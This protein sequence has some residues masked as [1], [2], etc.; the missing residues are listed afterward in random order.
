MSRLIRDI[1]KLV[2][3]MNSDAKRDLAVLA[4][5]VLG[6]IGSFYFGGELGADVRPLTLSRLALGAGGS[7]VGGYLANKVAKKVIKDN[8]EDDNKNIVN[9]ANYANLR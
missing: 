7:L 1:D 9:R 4:G 6:G 8:S 2:E 3:E 5:K